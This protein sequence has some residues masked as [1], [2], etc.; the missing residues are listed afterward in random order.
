MRLLCHVCVY[1]KV[2]PNKGINYITK[3]HILR[4]VSRSGRYVQGLGQGSVTGGVLVVIEGEHETLSFGAVGR[5]GRRLLGR[6][7][8]DETLG[9]GTDI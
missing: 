3:I 7:G 5:D 4:F 1:F 9:I 6:E 8:H 2:S